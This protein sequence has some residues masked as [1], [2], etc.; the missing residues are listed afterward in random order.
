MDKGEI[1]GGTV[2]NFLRMQGIALSAG[3]AERVARGLAPL[4]RIVIR[5][6]STL[7]FELEPAAWHH[8][9]VHRTPQR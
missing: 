9:A 3:R 1:N 2:E 8:A 4:L 6:T 5:D 7:P